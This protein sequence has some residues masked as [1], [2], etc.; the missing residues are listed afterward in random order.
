MGVT[1]E[2]VKCP[3]Y[4]IFNIAS[5]EQKIKKMKPQN[6]QDEQI[7]N[8]MTKNLPKQKSLDFIPSFLFFFL[9]FLFFK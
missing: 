4:K 2:Q 1:T 8:T 5:C 3:K 9:F 6:E 7:T